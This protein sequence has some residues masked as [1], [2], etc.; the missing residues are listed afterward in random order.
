M[1]PVTRAT[2]DA[3]A[4]N[5]PSVSDAR[6]E[7]VFSDVDFQDLSRLAYQQAGIVLG[8]S[9]RNL[10]YKPP[11]TAFTGAQSFDVQGLPRSYRG[12]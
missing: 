10:V 5:L 7:F 4:D 12:K 11:V 8:E 1:P 2:A 6:R 9:K 3:T